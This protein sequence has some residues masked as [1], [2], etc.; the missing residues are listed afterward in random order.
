MD[1]KQNTRTDTK[2]G[3]NIVEGKGGVGRQAEN[4]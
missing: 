3:S 2:P 4:F 1:T